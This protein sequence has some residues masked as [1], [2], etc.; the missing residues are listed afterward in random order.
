VC[1]R[2]VALL[3]AAGNI[4]KGALQNRQDAAGEL[5]DQ[6]LSP[7]CQRLAGFGDDVRALGVRRRVFVPS[8]GLH[9]GMPALDP[10]VIEWACAGR[11]QHVELWGW[12]PEGGPYPGLPHDATEALARRTERVRI[13]TRDGGEIEGNGS[14]PGARGYTLDTRR[15]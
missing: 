13:A 15:H 4:R 12:R 2:N 7:R 3:H 8:P 6:E 10:L 9:P 11:T 5:V 14:W 1:G